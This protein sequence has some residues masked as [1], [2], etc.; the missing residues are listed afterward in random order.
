M[1][2]GRLSHRP[3]SVSSGFFR[4]V[5]AAGLLLACV[6]LGAG[7]TASAQAPDGEALAGTKRCYAC[8]DTDNVLLGPSY[9]AIAARHARERNVMTEVLAQKIIHGGAGNW[10]VVPMVPNEHVSLSE[11]RAIS[12]WIL[13][14]N[15]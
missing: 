10:G 4:E 13:G 8:H 9:R 15:E 5:V 7:V 1:R 11:A 3:S 6:V 12:E 2:A 14:L